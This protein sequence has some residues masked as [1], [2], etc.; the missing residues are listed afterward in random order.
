M[1]AL[2]AGHSKFS[3][4]CPTELGVVAGFPFLFDSRRVCSL[5]ITYRGVVSSV[6]LVLFMLTE[7][8]VTIVAL[9][10]S[11]RGRVCRSGVFLPGLVEKLGPEN[12]AAES[13]FDATQTVRWHK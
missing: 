6:E 5:N 13:M 10:E 9:G 1:Q 3:S 2:P 8:C 7:M 4:C 12:K 11:S